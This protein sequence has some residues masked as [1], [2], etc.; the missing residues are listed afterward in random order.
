MRQFDRD[1]AGDI[2]LLLDMEQS[3]QLGQGKDST[4]EHAV[5]LA[6]SLAAQSLY[7]ERAVGLAAYAAEPLL[8]PPAR[9][10]GQQWRM[11]QG[12]ALISA[13]S[14]IP[15]TQAL[16][17][18]SRTVRRGSAVLILTPNLS[19]DW[20]PLL[21]EFAQRGVAL[22]VALFD[23]RSFG[24]DGNPYALSHQ[25]ARIGV[26]ATILRQGDVGVAP[27]FNPQ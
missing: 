24:G 1:T 20:I 16:A 22:S 21:L 6:A 25:L 2:W 15:I 7:Q 17:D 18:L 12:L 19:G 26:P 8:I 4:E 14:Q 10:E 5:L 9:G 11:L 13:E 27:E 23:R 3:V